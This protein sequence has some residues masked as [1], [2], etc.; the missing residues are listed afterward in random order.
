MYTLFFSILLLFLI[1]VGVCVRV[2]VCVCRCCM[3]MQL[4][5]KRGVRFSSVQKIQIECEEH[6]RIVVACKTRYFKR[7]IELLLLI[8]K[9]INRFK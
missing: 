3:C 9:L 4:Q 7:R 8:C 5:L 2:R 1:C 6:I